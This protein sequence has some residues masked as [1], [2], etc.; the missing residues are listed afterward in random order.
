MRDADM[1]M[2][3]CMCLVSDVWRL[4][5]DIWRLVSNWVGGLSVICTCICSLYMSVYPDS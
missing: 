2:D 4:M 1:D 5:S 3:V